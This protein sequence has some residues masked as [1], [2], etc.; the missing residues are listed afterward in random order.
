LKYFLNSSRR[1]QLALAVFVVATG[2]A[3]SALGELPSWIRNIEATS[4][5]QAVFFRMMS[6]PGG[7][8]L[9]RRPP[10]ET[11]PALADLIKSQPRN[12]DLYSLRALED[13]QQLDFA[14]SESDWKSYVDTSSDKI[15]AQVA[16]AD[17]YRRRLRPA[18]EIRTLSLV[19]NAPSIAAEKLTSATQ[20][21]SWQSFE[22]IFRVIQAQGLPKDVS[23]AQ[24]RAWI[25]RYPQEQSIYARF[26]QF[27]VAQK[28]YAAA[29]QLIADY[30]K[31]F[32]NDQIFPV[33]AKA[34]VEYRQGSVREGLAVYE[35]SFQ[36]LW[37][38]ELVKSYFDLLRET[39][40]LRKFLDGARASLTTNPEDLNA[41]AR[42]FY[43]YQQQGKL[44]VAQQAVADFRLRKETGK[45]PWT[46]QELYVC[47]RLLADT[48]AYPEAA[49]YYFALY[50]SKGM[51]DAQEQ[52]VAGLTNLL[53]TAPETPIRFGSGE[54]SMYR[55]IAA[56]DQGPGYLNGILSL[57]LNTTEPAAK[58]SEEEQRAVPYFH[59]SRAAE[60]LALLDA[61]FPNSARRPELHARMLEFYAGAGESEAVIQGGREFL[62]NF[63]KAPQRTSVALLM[64]DA[65]SRKD[66]TSSEF[67]IYDSVLQELAAQAQNMP[68]GS[69]AEG[70]NSANDYVR[71]GTNTTEMES[72]D[73]GEEQ[74]T[75]GRAENATPRRPASQ[76]F[77]VGSTTSSARQAGARSPEYARVLERYLARLAEMK[78]IP[79]ALGVLR[80]EIDRNPDDPGLYERLAVFLDQNQLGIE[81]EE[82]YRRAIARFADRSWYDKLARFYLRY[83]KNA[84][85]E[86]LTREAVQT[87]NGSDLEHYFANVN[88]GSAALYLRLNQ[89]ANQ[90]FPHNPVFVRNLL[91]AYQQ[92]AT[93]N[94]AAWEELLRQHWFE[95]PALRNQF[96]EYLSRTG[97]LESE[98]SALRQSAPDADSWDGNPAA[99][100]FLAYA[101]LWRSH[102][103]ESA[104]ALK[105][106]AA[107]YPA[108]PEI[109]RT[110][111]SVYRSL[112]Y[113][114]PADTAVAAKI[115]D[116]LLQANPGDTQIIA[117][118]GD[119]YADR[120]LFAQ[121]APYWERIP[122]VSPGES[123]GYLE[124]ATIYW[125]YFDFD[126]ALRLLNQGRGRVGDP[127]LYSYEAG[128]IYE[129]KRD[130]A[131]AID[132]YVKG[133]LAGATESS[134]EA[135]L[136]VLA[137][138]SKF[139]DLVDQSTAKIAAP[140]NPSMPAVFLRVKVLEAQN[141]K[142]E[143]ETFLDM[144]ASSATSI[145]QAEDIENLAQQKSLETVRQHAL[146]K[147]A[148]L[149]TDP[150][151]RLQLRYALI[152]LYESRKDFQSAEKN[153][154][155]LYRENPRILGVV[156]STVDFYWRTKNYPQA[157]SV[158]L[159][160]AKDAYPGLSKQF[161]YEAARK[162]TE[163]KQYQPARELLVQLLKDSPYDG[164]YLAAMADTYAQSGDDHGLQQFYTD[165]I[166]LFRNSSLPADARK[167]QIA[168]LRRGLILALT[169]MKDYPGAVDQYIEL[170]NNFPEDDTL[171][172]EAALCSL[173]YQRQQ[174]LVD[175][176]AKTVAQSPRDYR[177]SMVL[178]RIHTNLE[179]Y[180]AAIDVYAK[181][182][183]IRP[184]RA[185]LYTARAGLEER[186]M[187]FDDAVSD[188][189]HIYQLAYKDPQWMEK[190][191]VVRARQ[192]KANEVVAALKAALID[193][194]PE[195]A[196]NYFEVARRLESWGMLAEA[197][198][199]AEQGV[200]TAGADLLAM[201]EHHAGAKTYVRIM[202]RV[203]QQQQAYTAMQSAL[204]DASSNLPVL[205]E[206]IAKQGITGVT[207]EQWRERVRQTRI[208]TARNGMSAVLEEMGN[209]V[210]TYFTP[211]ERLAFASFAESKRKVMSLADLEKFGIPLAQS[212]ALAD[213]E[214]HWRF[215]LMMQQAI[216]SPNRYGNMQPLV[217][218]QRRRG[219]FAELG[220]Q[221]EGYANV[222]LPV[223]RGTAV[224]AAA[225][226]YR[227]AGDQQNELRLLSGISAYGL[228]NARQQ[229]LFQLL[230]AHQPQEL[231]RIG[232]TWNNPAGEQAADFVVAN[233]G[234]ALS[235][236]VVQA[237][238]RLRTPVWT[239]SYNAL[240]GLYFSEPTADVNN[241]FLGALGDDTI[242]ERL[243]KPVDRSQQ[244]AGNTW[245]YYGSRYGEYLGT[246]RQGKA[247]DFLPAILEQ[248]PA[249][250]SGYL[251]LADY[252]AG[253][254]DLQHA[255]ADY[256]HTLELS[257]NRPDVYDSLAVAHYKQG[258]RAA[259][260][261]QWKQAFA[262]LS[263]QIDA[264]HTP[265][266]FWTDFGRTCDQLRTRHLFADL[267]PDADAI[268]RTYLR[269]NGNYRSNALLQPAYLAVGEPV[270]AT[271]WLVDVS[272]A[273]HDPTLILSDVADASWIPLA[274][275]EPIY[276]RILESKQDALGKLTGFERDNTQQDL[277]SWQ[278][279]WIKY[280]VR[281]KQYAQAAD[282]IAALPKETR[283]AQAAALVPLDLQV[284]AQL[285]TLDSRIAGYRAQPQSVPASNILR[286]AAR[287][288]F[289][290]GD[291]QSARKIL[292]FVFA[293][294]IDEHQLVAANF[295]G[296]AE[297]R[298]ASGDTPGALDLLR[299]LV[300]VVGNPFENLDPAAALLEK[301]G[302][303]AEA[304]EFLDQLVKSMPWDPSYR[305]RLAKVRIAAGQN[306][307]PSQDALASIASGAEVPYGLRIK[308][309]LA[310]AGQPHAD[311]G[312]G[313]LDLL[314]GNSAAIPAT[315]A[316]KF[317]FYE[318]RI[319]AAQNTADSQTKIQLLSH[320]VIDFPRR[321]EARVPL[322]E[323]AASMRSDEFALG[324]LEPLLQ[325][326]F[327]GRHV[328][329]A[330]EEQIVS[331][332]TDEEDNNDDSTAPTSAALTLSRARQAQ[333]AQMIGDTMMRLDRLTD[334]LS[335]F[336]VARRSENSAAARKE[337]KRKIANAKATLRLQHQNAARQPLLHE[338]L[339]QDRVV[340]PRLL[341]G[342]AP[343]PKAAVAKGGLKQ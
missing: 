237:R 102:F 122:Q 44:D 339:E 12:A 109:A 154:A 200:K 335:Y 77:E 72:E 343:A 243:A 43:Y 4:A 144:I 260:L 137:R 37:D 157:I 254:G 189:E 257:P 101:N 98:L 270:S 249:T 34:M 256:N 145:E 129:N 306:A 6:L 175:F 128:A 297:I 292:E 121:A 96:F 337:L 46:S 153:V 340:R 31:Q 259:A 93:R 250:S 314:A 309:A 240:I 139:R 160:A 110:A 10:R 262:M 3:I 298:L 127:T 170:I 299:R 58:Y 322:F 11:R 329:A 131:H 201:P 89:Y 220:P 103:E 161:T 35:Q 114:D 203:R 211:E 159:E 28:E 62:A 14:A 142:Q 246:T 286:T 148:A 2:W 49:R 9:F 52:A 193:G 36:P 184:D 162:S 146:E 61:R 48:H 317:Y 290:A 279:R 33:K 320:C 88:G 278:V 167:A 213:Q 300:V 280:L 51:P 82:V 231:V 235:H 75:G 125:D 166:A 291:K 315:A 147:Q 194:R 124:A 206:Q 179:N 245:F 143:M 173:R 60:L 42:I 69:A 212:A 29:G 7:S 263:R 47:A 264:A 227:A 338:A 85:F 269:H 26:L 39:Q 272:S 100:N 274:Q 327:L 64:A 94:L 302:H 66:D 32:P 113:F 116:N 91:S 326:Q 268:I 140:P 305:L 87:F 25:A 308:A 234:A 321:D 342:A 205:K 325:T 27:L 92:P 225:D 90:R 283:D 73:E 253:S 341:A 156:R 311:L 334:A 65:Y 149:T 8:V 218:L 123:G 71:A 158:L 178:A 319:K 289:E 224:L 223:L 186:L 76:A 141:R 266:T 79:Q 136:L 55:D 151:T 67:A 316:D 195:N 177:W 241:A 108:E 244:L 185:D 105:S 84:E 174:Q 107:Q 24:Y 134:A 23:I 248:S 86:Q 197:R 258:D 5:L 106:L 215:E 171:V 332:D 294:E 328:S 251:T 187:R 196:A 255:I 331:S 182:I 276:Q 83:R 20:Q 126:N 176:Y 155:V 138:R 168:T 208:E 210:N 226:A 238:G 22:R 180:P 199:F 284:A 304:I 38:P 188:Y 307:A 163:A 313:E 190:V 41:M 219:R 133:S 296:L 120:D 217:D 118:I 57:I 119:I 99:A 295:L 53:L 50:N 18:D 152:Q 132:E 104:P 17:F 115:E 267:R 117:R 45:S 228:D 183:A 239:K 287:Q 181:A 135:R 63:P 165:K 16:L 318:A 164:E 281:T 172:T 277:N 222:L 209:T 336:E 21:R 81:Q 288:L 282:A 330:E 97:K 80:H 15:S 261:G 265:E 68:L 56:M 214:A 30:R 216:A 59:R 275:R 221:L 192:G 233:G 303:N 247:E 252:Y 78:Q 19:A 70:L 229:R 323:A 324:V 13:E 285:G 54:L 273:A 310:L 202:T 230:L 169:R 198:S 95:E 293:R 74:D 112:A 150:V 333:T 130:Y 301:A 312:S 1:R 111:S 236:A 40:N 204:A 271:A 191:A 232:S 242:A 207:D